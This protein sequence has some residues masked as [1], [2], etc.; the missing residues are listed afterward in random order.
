MSDPHCSFCGQPRGAVRFLL[1]GPNDV[2]ICG[3]CIALAVREMVEGKGLDD[4]ERFE[5]APILEVSKFDGPA[6]LSSGEAVIER[7]KGE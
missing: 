3:E 2:A 5:N 4:A 1:F 6:A 7:D